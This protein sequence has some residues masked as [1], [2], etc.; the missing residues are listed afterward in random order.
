MQETPEK[1]I[2]SVA[3]QKLATQANPSTRSAMTNKETPRHC[4]VIVI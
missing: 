1:I 2:Y 4:P 3:N